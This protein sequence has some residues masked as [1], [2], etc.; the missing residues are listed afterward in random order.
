MTLQKN[1]ASHKEHKGLHKDH[2]THLISLI[3]K[4]K[5]V[6]F[7]VH[8]VNFVGTSSIAKRVENYRKKFWSRR[9]QTVFLHSHLKMEVDLLAQLVERNTFNVGALGS[10]PRGI[11]KDTDRDVSVSFFY[12]PHL[13]SI[14]REA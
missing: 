7:V 12:A 14:F 1:K 6:V 5:L 2:K 3:S 4:R 10:S 13:H 9:P 8:F 11:T